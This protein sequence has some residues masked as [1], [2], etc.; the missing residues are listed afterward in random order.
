MKSIRFVRQEDPRGCLVACVAMVTG[1]SYQSAREWFA[2]IGKT[3]AGPDGGLLDID[4]MA[5]LGTYGYAYDRRY[6]WWGANRPR[7]NWTKPFAPAHIVAV[8]SNGAHAVV[9]TREGFVFDPAD[10]HASRV[11]AGLPPKTL[12]DYSNVEYVLGVWN[13]RVAEGAFQAFG[14]LVEPIRETARILGYAVAVHG[15]LT[16]DVDLIACPWRADAASADDLAAAVID[17]IK[18]LNDGVAIVH[19]DPHAPIG[20]YTRRNPEPKPHGRLAWSIHLGGGP[21]IDLSVMPRAS[22]APLT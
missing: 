1:H 22:S 11:A 2:N 21:Y 15:S 9:M 17:T 14:N 5:Y 7:E 13:A 10:D 8:A 3:F 6:R 18:R 19:N 16:R 20:D 4:V 12:A